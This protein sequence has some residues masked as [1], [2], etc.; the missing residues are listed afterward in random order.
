VPGPG[1]SGVGGGGYGTGTR[2]GGGG[3][4]VLYG[5]TVRGGRGAE[6]SVAYDDMDGYLEEA[7]ENL[8][9][10]VLMS[11]AGVN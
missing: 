2:G 7:E 6:A 9:Y 4:G 11:A 10:S 1:S 8:D 5:Q 3:G